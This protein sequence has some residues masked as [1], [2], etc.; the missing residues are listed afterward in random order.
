MARGKRAIRQNWLEI[1]GL[2]AILI[3]ASFMLRVPYLPPTYCY[4][5]PPDPQ[6]W[7]TEYDIEAH[8]EDQDMFSVWVEITDNY[9]GLYA[10]LFLAEEGSTW[11][12][13]T[14]TKGVGIEGAEEFREWSGYF[15]PHHDSWDIKVTLSENWYDVRPADSDTAGP[16]DC[17]AA[18]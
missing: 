1:C 2:A 9:E 13:Y 14:A 11:W 5:D 8:Y 12:E 17:P 3:L 16:V 7:I 15:A 4:A 6:I 18:Q 10:H